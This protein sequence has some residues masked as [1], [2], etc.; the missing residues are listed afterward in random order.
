MPLTETLVHKLRRVLMPP[1][2]G[3]VHAE[4][5][6]DLSWRRGLAR[7]VDELQLDAES[8]SRSRSFGLRT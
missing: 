1:Y 5:H 2:A 3:Y 6:V 8:H 4:H 7:L